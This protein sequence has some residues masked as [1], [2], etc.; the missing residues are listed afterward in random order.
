[1]KTYKIKKFFGIIKRDCY[2]AKS[3]YLNPFFKQL[4]ERNEKK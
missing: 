4:F 3:I 1:M 2:I